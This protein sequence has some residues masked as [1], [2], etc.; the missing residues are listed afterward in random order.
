MK[1][2]NT[3]EAAGSWFVRSR[4]WY[5]L[6]RIILAESHKQHRSLFG[7]SFVYFSL[8]I[9]PGI[10]LATVYYTFKPFLDVPQF[11]NHWSLA[12][13][14]HGLFLFVA[15]G[16][17]G[18]IFFWSLVQSA[19]QFSWERYNGTLELLFLTPANR[20]VLILANGATALIQSTWLFLIF[21][22]GLIAIVGGLRVAHPGMFVVAFLGLLIPAIAWGAFLNSIFIFSRDSGLL[23]SLL[24]EPMSFFSGARLPLTA[25][26]VWIQTVGTIFPLTTSLIV[27]R[28]ALLEAAGVTDL[29]PHLLLLAGLS[30][31]LLL[32]SSYLLRKGEDRARQNGDY[33]LF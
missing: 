9:W 20:L 14:P 28:G 24:E 16:M 22:A 26:P 4:K 27:L 13:I 15:T 25:M 23:Y 31:M 11:T 1:Q 3:E 30:L 2:S 12:N 29:W 6:W 18:F 10:Q 32:L 17:L 5:S 8:L 21:I 7:S 33:N 19:W